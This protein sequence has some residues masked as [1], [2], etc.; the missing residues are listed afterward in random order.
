MRRPPPRRA[1]LLCRAAARTLT[2]THAR[3][4]LVAAVPPPE[5]AALRAALVPAGFAVIDVAEVAGATLDYGGGSL[6]VPDAPGDAGGSVGARAVYLVRPTG[7]PAAP[8]PAAAYPQAV[9]DALAD[10]DLP[11]VVTG[12]SVAGHGGGSVARAVAAVAAAHAA[13]H[14]LRARPLAAD[15]TLPPLDPPATV[16]LAATLDAGGAWP[17]GSCDA[18]ALAVVD[19]LLPPA[20]ASLLLAAM[21]VPDADAEPPAGGSWE[22]GA[23]VDRVGDEGTWGLS[24]AA[25]DALLASPPPPL[26]ALESRIASLFAETYDVAYM[27]SAAIDG[28]L[29]PLVANAVLPTDPGAWHADGDPLC[30]DPDGPWAAAVGL[31]RNRSPGRPLF[32]SAVVYLQDWPLDRHGETLAVDGGAG[33]GVCVRPVKG[34]VFLLEQD[35]AHRIVAT[36]GPGGPRF[37][38]VLKLVFWPKVV[39]GER[40]EGLLKAAWGA[41]VRLGSAASVVAA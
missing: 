34:R 31:E 13:A 2:S 37:S 23:A 8:S 33:V 3:P 26:L 1:P 38:L 18:T 25:V 5:L 39:Q 27:P 24:A 22:R 16:A 41:P 19:G 30:A 15:P 21:G 17:D 29:S 40:P 12:A 7:D 32:V 14:G 36:A 28:G 11:A 9:L 35:L 10:A 20:D 6:I 4:L